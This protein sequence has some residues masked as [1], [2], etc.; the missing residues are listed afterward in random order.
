MY[1]GIY[2]GISQFI[3]VYQ[4]I[5]WYILVYTGI[6]RYILVYPGISR[7]ITVYPGLSCYILVY[8][9]PGIHVSWYI[10]VYPGI[11]WCLHN[12]AKNNTTLGEN[13]EYVMSALP[14]KAKRQ[15]LLT[16]KQILPFGFTEQFWE[17]II[18]H[19][20][21]GN[22]SAVESQKAVSV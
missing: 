1:P 19:I 5:Y 2:P 18:S 4:D 7:Y 22:C 21:V 16:S 15:Y 11:L 3:Q 9:Y 20:L 13:G 6:S 10:L 17:I 14:C 12:C 8:M